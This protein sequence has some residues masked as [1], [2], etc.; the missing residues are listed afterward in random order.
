[1]F[2]ILLALG[3]ATTSQT[4]AAPP[5]SAPTSAPTSAPA[6]P[7]PLD[8][9]ALTGLPFRNIGPALMEGRIVDIAV[10]P[11]DH[12]EYCVAAASGGVWKTVNAGT[13]FTPVFDAA[14]SYSI[15]CIAIDP[16]NPLTVWVGS[17]EN[18]SQRSVGFGDGVY[19]T[20][21]GGKTWENLGLRDSEHIGMIRIDPRDSDTVYVA[22]QGPLWRAGPER[23]LYKTTDGGRSWRPVLR[24]SEHT[25][26]SEVHLDPR[27]PDT[28]Y[29]AAYQRRRHV[30]TLIDGG[31][32]S[33]IYKSTDGGQS[34]RKTTRG[35]PGVDL[36]RIGLAVAPANP[37][38]LYAIV[39][40]ADG[41]GGIFRSTDRGESWEKRSGYMASSPQYYCELFV[42]PSDAQH[43]YSMDTFLSEA[44]DGGKSWKRVPI[45]SVHVD[46]HA[47]WIDPG[48]PR[49]MLTGNDGGLYETW[50][51]AANWNYKANLPITQF[52]RVCTDNAT[53]FY[54]V[55]GG[56]QDNNTE[57]GPSRT[58][59]RIGI[60]NEHWFITVGGDGFKSQVDPCEP[61]IV[62]SQYQHGGLIRFDRRTGETVDIKPREAFGAEGLR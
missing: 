51:A 60:A 59:D 27:D 61:N 7:K 5:A 9:A 62:Y 56:T 29:A 35:L 28:L 16:A 33:A 20:R 10:N 14:G 36:G 3:L 43:V 30:W 57:G 55:Y 46:F 19:R 47:L 49:H 48:N 52:Y 21:D 6:E 39:E 31:P 18:N 15:G 12:S 34:W 8:A 37:D 2:A 11:R 45:E 23:G 42:D 53:P 40:A 13:T 32:E 1:M 26:I 50:D 22:A 25:G 41:E 24:V 54:N 38:V 58:L 44:R 4:A 17:G